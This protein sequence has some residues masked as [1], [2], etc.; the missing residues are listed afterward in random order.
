MDFTDL[1]YHFKNTWFTELIVFM[2]NIVALIICF[3]KRS[4]LEYFFAFYFFL[5]ILVLLISWSITTTNISNTTK[6]LI[7]NTLNTMIT[8]VELFTYTIFFRQLLKPLIFKYVLLI[9]FCIFLAI[10]I[11][12]LI[13]K[14]SFLTDRYRYIYSLLNVLEFLILITPCLIYYYNLF[15]T[16]TAMG[17]FLRPS[18]WIVTGIFT[19][20]VISIPFYLLDPL[21]WDIKARIREIFG[22]FLFQLP[23]I[24][25]LTFLIRGLQCKRL[26]TT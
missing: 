26:L 24:I 5:N 12:Y 21:L 19:F 14:F 16:D 1:I 4:T 25:N 23:I 15:N 22:V 20:S 17:L 8:I 10:E 11:M 13:T 18:F 2:L 3:K 6:G 7:F 9:P